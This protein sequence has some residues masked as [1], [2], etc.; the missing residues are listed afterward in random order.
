MAVTKIR[1]NEQI[2]AATITETELNTSVA[3]NGI[4]GGGG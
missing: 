1:G 3:G 4:K 2:K